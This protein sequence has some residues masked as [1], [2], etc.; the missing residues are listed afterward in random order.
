MEYQQ[1]KNLV[2]GEDYKRWQTRQYDI[3]QSN[4]GEGSYSTGT[5]IKFDT[6]MLRSKLANF[7]EAYI[8]VQGRMH[9]GTM[10]ALF[11]ASKVDKAFC[12]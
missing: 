7:A 3:V 5:S 4:I 10:A 12:F 8:L 1:I 6:K 9:S 11:L 2:V